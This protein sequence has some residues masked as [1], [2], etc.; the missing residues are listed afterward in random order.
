MMKELMFLFLIL[1]LIYWLDFFMIYFMFMV[2][3]ILFVLN[4]NSMTEGKMLMVFYIDSMGYFMILLSYWIMFMVILSMKNSSFSKVFFFM[5][6]M[7]M[8]ILVLCFI[9]LNLMWFYIFFESILIP[10][11]LMIYIWG[12]QL[13]RFKA[14]VYMFLYTIFGSFPLMLILMYQM[15]VKSI[16]FMYLMYDFLGLNFELYFLYFL[17]MIL[18]FLI[19]FPMYGFHLWL[20]KAHVEAPVGGSMILAGV[21]LKL[22]GYGLYRFMNLIFFKNLMN[23]DC[24]IYVLS[25]VGSLYISIMCM[26]QV[27]LKMLIAYSSVSHMGLVILG[28]MSGSMWGLQG[29]L[30]MMISHGLCSS[31]MF[32]MSNLLYL[33]FYTR[34]LILLKGMMKIFPFFSLFWFFSCSFNMGMPPSMNMLGEILLMGSILKYS[35]LFV[36][37]I[38]LIFIFSSVFNLYLMSYIFHGK[39]YLENFVFNLTIMDYSIMYFH[40]LPLLI[41]IL[42]MDMFYIF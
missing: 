27:D 13:E 3:F 31:L 24:F 39:M 29:S 26:S 42:K 32:F 8:L 4:L 33:R 17:F 25:L 12:N 11:M 9:S 22:G 6:F 19:K 36:F 10:M 35:F 28:L 21:L 16:S 37:L 41:Y 2:S 23:Y 18:G 30:I 14:G 38:I 20:P 5:M 40:I 34:N 15:Q 7:M 1:I